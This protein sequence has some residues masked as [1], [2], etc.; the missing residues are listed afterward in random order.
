MKI[1]IKFYQRANDNNFQVIFAGIA[2]KLEKKKN[3]KMFWIDVQFFSLPSVARDAGTED[4]FRCLDI[5]PADFWKRF[6]Q[7]DLIF[8]PTVFFPAKK[9]LQSSHY[10]N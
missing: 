6:H 1:W 8:R 10:K 3:G 4:L 2:L 9:Y 5:W 7:M